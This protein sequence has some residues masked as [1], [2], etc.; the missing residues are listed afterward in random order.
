MGARG[1]VGS[2]GT[3]LGA[4]GARGGATAVGG[5]IRCVSVKCVDVGGLSRVAEFHT[6]NKVVSMNIYSNKKKQTIATAQTHRR[7]SLSSQ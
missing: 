5:R 1:A 3:T 4:S 7:M 2:T 6:C